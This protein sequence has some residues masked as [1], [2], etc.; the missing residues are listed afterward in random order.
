[1]KSV[2]LVFYGKNKMD[3]LASPMPSG[4]VGLKPLDLAGNT[5]MQGTLTD[6]V[7]KT[8]TKFLETVLVL[9]WKALYFNAILFH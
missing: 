7:C 2:C 5:T 1:M 8:G 6:T 9:A 4:T 3:V